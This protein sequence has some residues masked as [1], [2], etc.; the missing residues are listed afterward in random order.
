MEAIKVQE[1]QMLTLS[2]VRQCSNATQASQQQKIKEEIRQEME[3]LEQQLIHYQGELEN[4]SLV[5]SAHSPFD[6]P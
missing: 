2:H 5:L 3:R 1:A 4:N 6:R